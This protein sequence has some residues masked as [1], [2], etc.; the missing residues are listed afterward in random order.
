[1]STPILQRRKWR[2]W[3]SSS[4]I[5]C[6]R[7]DAWT[8]F[9]QL[10]PWRILASILRTLGRG[11]EWDPMWLGDVLVIFCVPIC[12]PSPSFSTCSQPRRLTCVGC[13]R[14]FSPSIWLP[15]G[16]RSEE[17]RQWSPGIGLRASCVPHVKVTI[18]VWKYSLRVLKLLP[19]FTSSGQ[20]ITL[21]HC[22]GSRYCTTLVGSPH[23]FTHFYN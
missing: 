19:Q 21:S 6:L 3:E 16:K 7:T 10:P 15:R 11:L 13:M 22:P 1:M 14:G 17:G 4:P 20:K 9:T 18:S 12:L 2:L 5:T 23:P 8:S